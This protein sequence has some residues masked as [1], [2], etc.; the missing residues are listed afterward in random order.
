MRCSVCGLGSSLCLICYEQFPT[1]CALL[2]L[3]RVPSSDR[4]LRFAAQALFLVKR[5]I[6]VDILDTPG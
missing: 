4:Y 6:G 1:A 5:R 2:D 3:W